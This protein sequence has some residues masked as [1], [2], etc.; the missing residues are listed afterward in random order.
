MSVQIKFHIIKNFSEL[1]FTWCKKNLRLQNSKGLV[2]LQMFNGLKFGSVDKLNDKV[3]SEIVNVIAAVIVG[4][5]TDYFKEYNFIT[6]SVGASEPRKTSEEKELVFG[7][8]IIKGYNGAVPCCFLL[9]CQSLKEFREES[10]KATFEAMKNA[11]T[12]YM[13]E[14]AMKKMLICIAADGAAVNFGK[15]HDT[16]NIMKHLVGWDLYCIYCTNHQLKVSIK[17]SFKNKS[18][19][20]DLKEMLDTLYRL[21]KNGSKS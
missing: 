14:E 3:C 20:N 11:I 21:F 18:T 17:G 7:K 15:H 1:Y 13:S 16:L 6:A 12:T 8:V 2:E 9:K 10:R 5:L 19:F 4:C